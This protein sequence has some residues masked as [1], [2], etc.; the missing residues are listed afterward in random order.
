[1]FKKIL[2]PLVISAISLGIVFYRFPSLPK[3][4]SYDEVQFAKLAL[5]LNGKPYIPYS[6]LATGHATLY[7][8]VILLS[9]KIFGI[10]NFALRFPAAFF[11]ILNPLVFYFILKLIFKKYFSFPRSILPSLL[12]LLL[13]IVFATSRWYFNFARFSFE[14]TFLLFLEL[15]SLYFLLKST[16][17]HFEP[18]CRQARHLRSGQAS[19]KEWVFLN[20]RNAVSGFLIISGIF[21]GLAFN[22][23]TPGR[24][25]F[26]LPLAILAIKT[27]QQFNNLAIKRLLYFVIPFVIII[28]PLTLYLLIH[29]DIR[30]DQ[31]FFLKNTEL[32]T[33]QKGEFLA[34]NIVFTA[35]E[36]NVKGDVNGRHNYPYKPALNPILGILFLAGLVIAIQRF[37]NTNNLLFL[38]YF[39]LSLIPAILTYPWENPS[40]LRTFTAIPAIVYF[41]GLSIAALLKR[42][43]K[44]LLLIICILLF[45]SAVYEIRTYFFYQSRVFPAAF[46]I[47]QSLPQAMVK[48]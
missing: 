11:G 15:I 18:A 31:E 46:E 20:A 43:N 13:S 34:D 29:P 36:F 42:S 44:L 33:Q 37:S 23:Y 5:S 4:L 32:S 14:V 39:L 45:V 40:M 6:P 1:M 47:K 41:I 8:Y 30:I 3:N 2:P 19:A 38:I 35:L 28:I 17:T 9:F 16:D 24:I 48:F 26:L 10:N 25:F 7:F 21:A 22:S 12:P 27:I